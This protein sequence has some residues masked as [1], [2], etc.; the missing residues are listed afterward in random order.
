MA[1]AESEGRLNPTRTLL[2]YNAGVITMDTANR[3]YTRGAVLIQNDRIVR[4]GGSDDLLAS[5][6]PGTEAVDLGG[7]W[8]LPGLINTHVHTSQHLG[9]GLGDD[10]SLLT[11]LQERIWPYE[12]Q[13]TEEDSYVSSLLCG[14]EQI[15]S[16]VTCFAEA[17][18]QH[19]AGMA[20]A[21]SELGL[22]ACLSRST[23]DTGSGLPERWSE[24]TDEALAAQ[25]ANHAAW[26][27]G[28]GGRLRV[29]LGVRTI[30]NASDALLGRT[31]EL[32]DQLGVGIHMH[33]AE[34][35]AEVDY[36]RE[37]RGRSTVEHLEALGVL[38]ANLLAVHCV[39]LTEREIEL[40][41]EREVKV[42]HNP[43]AAMRYLGFARIPEMIEAGICVALGT[44]GAP[45]NNRM[46]L[47]DEMWLASLIHKGRTLNPV[48]MPAETVLG[49]VTR[50][51]ARAVLWDDALGSLEAGKKADLVVVNPNTPNM[52]P[53][54][55][56]VANVVT[57]M[58]A[59]NIE[60]VMCDGRWLMRDGRIVAVDEA[61]VVA[62]ARR[63]AAAIVARAGL[64]LPPRL[65]VVN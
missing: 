4:V 48:V 54:H 23:M 44:D 20:R 36:A 60:S 5:A 51:G 24:N 42:S 46:T 53:L 15:R 7:R 52:L 21:V 62:E 38:G 35:P 65:N 8:L 13:L 18:G 14:L 31:K 25:L 26:H 30:F 64:A 61:Q 3:Q 6:E 50:Q 40:F 49:L 59:H 19:V 47:V 27:N 2:L 10:V 37:T 43:A 63:R 33:V 56:P 41:A 11:W 55:D 39:W 45:S 57:A 22:R 17:G 28:A 29:W 32:A 58:Q 1:R 12:S 9:R 34:I 16:G